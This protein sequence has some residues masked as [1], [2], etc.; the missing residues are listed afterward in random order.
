MNHKFINKFL[1]FLLAALV[2]GMTTMPAQA[3]M[4]GTDAIVSAQQSQVDRDQLLSALQRDDIKT[5]LAK[6][7]VD[8][9][10][11]AERVS[12]LTDAEVIELNNRLGELPAG[13]DTAGVLI[14]IIV[15]LIITEVTGVTDIF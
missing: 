12:R 5:E 8:A 13:G 11:A 7:G 2:M 15:V 10:D 3:A 14:V 6:M 9:A 4:V 1:S